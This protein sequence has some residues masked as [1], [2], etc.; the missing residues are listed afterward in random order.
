MADLCAAFPGRLPSEIDAEVARLPA[1]F[2]DEVLE[3]RAYRQA[4]SMTDEADTPEAR[5]RLPKTPLFKLVP[6][7]ERDI[8]LEEIESRE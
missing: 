6:V 1:G 2:L 3:A 4:K 8:A 5:K 7:I